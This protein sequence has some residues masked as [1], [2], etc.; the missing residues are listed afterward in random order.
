MPRPALHSPQEKA[1]LIAQARL[2]LREGMKQKEIA[3]LL[4][5]GSAS[6]SGW[7]REQMLD[8]WLPPVEPSQMPRARRSE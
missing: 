5:I 3:T 8:Q 1:A 2:W 6:L 7:L 4:G